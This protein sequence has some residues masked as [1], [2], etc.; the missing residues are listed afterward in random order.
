MAESF[1]VLLRTFRQA[2]FMSQEELAE[3]AGLSAAAVGALERG[4]RRHPYP[5]TVAALAQAM[6]LTPA[7]RA[8]LVEGLPQRSVR[9]GDDRP[10]SDPSP[11]PIPLTPLVGR[12]NELATITRLLAGGR[13]RWVTL[14]GPGGV[15]K[16]RLA[17]EAAGTLRGSFPDGVPWVDLANVRARDLVVPVIARALGLTEDAE[18]RTGVVVARYLTTR[19]LLLV[20][21]NLEQID[22]VGPLILDLI[23]AA[24]GVAVLGT[25]R[26][27]LRVRGEH[28]VRVAPLAVP[29]AA[30]PGM[31][32]TDAE[33]VF[34]QRARAVLP[35][36]DPGDGSTHVAAICRQLDGMPLALELAAAQLRYA[37]LAG[38]REQLQDR[39]TPLQG[40]MQDLPARQRSLRAS[41]Q[42]SYDLLSGRDR[43]VFARAAVFE[44]GFTMAAAL[45][46]CGGASQGTVD[47]ECAIAS[48]VDRSLLAVSRPP[49]G[50]ARFDMLETLRAFALERLDERGEHPL[51]ATRHRHHYCALA[52]EAARHL[53]TAGRGPWLE[54]LDSETGN[55]NAALAS[56]EGSGDTCTHMRL[57]AALGWFW[58]LRGRFAEGRRWA[59]SALQVDVGEC[60]PNVASGCRYTAAALAWKGNEL[61]RAR[62]LVDESVALARDGERRRL[63]L[64]LGLSGLIAISESRA[65]RAITPLEESLALFSGAQDEWGIAYARSNLGDALVQA[66]EL[67]AAAAQYREALNGFRALGDQWGQAL[68]LHMLGTLAREAG[69]VEAARDQYGRSVE[70]CRAIGNGENLARG[71]VGLAAT[72]LARDDA[73]SAEQ[74]LLESL[75]I[76]DGIGMAGAAAA[77]LRGLAGVCAA[78]GE[79]R[80][81]AAMFGA[82][83][84]ADARGPLFLI[85]ADLFGEQEHATKVALGASDFSSAMDAGRSEYPGNLRAY[86]TLLER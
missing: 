59:R 43:G 81:A 82:A 83:E 7:E 9:P 14:T 6:E 53:P 13:A 51:V 42:W 61:A 4:D 48:L 39:M 73:D 31:P 68:V 85:G 18:G 49:G 50:T 70:L 66:H 54:V 34:L 5:H 17:L 79:F 22:D 84:A 11:L 27:A 25:S 2:R 26:A 57:V 21:D 80:Q 86:H 35:D 58:N 24:P 63:A 33:E 77:V 29:A 65:D 23:H 15:G 52:D 46:V 72:A 76:L 45:A 16:T 30:S 56:A 28:E 3:R 8:Q 55:L 69:D 75:D 12:S 47:V 41:V 38:L 78:R 10:A 40:A 60:D 67:E 62:V 74:C 20:L 37:T 1:G 71:L 32:T 36:F 19:C 64:A 44:G